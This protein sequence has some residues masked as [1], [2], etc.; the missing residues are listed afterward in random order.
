MKFVAKSVVLAA[1]AL[2]TVGPSYAQPLRSTSIPSSLADDE[3][4]LLPEVM[5]EFYGS[6]NKE[7]AC[8]VSEH[9]DGEFENNY[10]M[11][12]IRLD[13]R[14]S[15]GQ[16]ALFIV[17]FGQQL[18]EE[19][20]PTVGGHG[21]SGGLGLIVLTPNGA[22]LG[23]VATNNL[24]EWFQTCNRPP[25]HNAITIQRLGPNG[26]YGWIAKS[27]EDHSG[28]EYEWAKVYGMIGNSVEPLT[29]ITSYYS[30]EGMSGCGPEAHCTALSVKYVFESQSSVGTFYPIMLR[31]S[32]INKGRAFRG[33]Y[34]LAFDKNLL[35]YLVPNNMP[36]EIKP[37]P[38]IA[39]PEPGTL[40]LAC[41]G[42]INTT[43]PVSIGIVVNFTTRTVQ[44][45]LNPEK[46]TG[47]DDA[48]VAFVEGSGFVG[49]IDR[50][51]GDTR[52]SADGGAYSLQCRP[53]E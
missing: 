24:Y 41:K 14:L 42:T 12:P 45:G 28:R 16:K 29:T 53:V 20:K 48:K 27:N 52:A 37:A 36:D 31:V 43:D 30:N 1:L 40:S 15:N 26:A 44:F 11:K 34:R 18:D 23:V 5:R 6:F 51:S 47:L 49:T 10:C 39:L 25:N 19:G 8:W 35:T 9:K 32:G 2:M 3:K 13:V 46:I 33:N 50:V 4:R 38:F 7:K 22:T 21:R 17:V